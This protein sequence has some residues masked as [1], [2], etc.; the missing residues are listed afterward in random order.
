MG[1][2]VLEVV[3]E[4]PDPLPL[5]NGTDD[6]DPP[7]MVP[8]LVPLPPPKFGLEPGPEPYPVLVVTVRPPFGFAGCTSMA[9]LAGCTSLAPPPMKG[10][11][12]LV[13]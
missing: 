1:L 6:V 5:R 7:V 4:E 9:G 10:L 3:A 2:P 12:A 11:K 13:G 8:E